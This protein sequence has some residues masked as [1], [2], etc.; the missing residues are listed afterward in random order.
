MF[1]NNGFKY[2]VHEDIFNRIKRII[3]KN[4]CAIK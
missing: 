4:N 3:N 2:F 1:A